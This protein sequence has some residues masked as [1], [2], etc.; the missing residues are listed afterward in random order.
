MISGV[1]RLDP[2]SL[3]VGPDGV[4]GFHWPVSLAELRVVRDHCV[5][6]LL[7]LI[8]QERQN[9]NPEAE[10]LRLIMLHALN[11]VTAIYMATA[12][13]RRA[14]ASGFA[15]EPAPGMRLAPALL[16]GE[17]PRLPDFVQTLMRGPAP[18]AIGSR[19]RRWLRSQL[20]QGPIRHGRVNWQ[21]DIVSF[22]AADIVA[23]H[24]AKAGL[25]VVYRAF[26]TWFLPVRQEDILPVSASM[27]AGLNALIVACFEAGGEVVPPIATEHLRRVFCQA[28]GTCGVH[29]KRLDTSHRIPRRLWT[30]SGA[31]IWGRM[32]RYVVRSRGGEVTG[33]DHGTGAGHLSSP[34]KPFSEFQDCSRFVTFTPRQA[35]GLRRQYDPRY[36]LD[37]AMPELV[38][39]RQ[40]SG[41]VPVVH[42][43]APKTPRKIIY[44][45]ALSD[46]EDVHFKPLWPD[47][48]L[49][50]LQARTLSRLK[51]WGFDV[52][53][54][55]YP[56]RRAIQPA[57]FA[58]RL[59]ITSLDGRFEDVLSEADVVILESHLSTTFA[60]AICSDKPIVLLDFELDAL[61]PEARQMLERRAVLVPAW[62]DESNRAQVDWTIFRAGIEESGRRFDPAFQ[63]AFFG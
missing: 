63:K 62:F 61:A 11:E 43:P 31:Q 21:T 33:H 29:L 10:W 56:S 53:Y 55:P 42:A 32:L 45:A 38:V 20:Q 58:D 46:G 16:K 9:G 17:A 7:G 39:L 51:E 26:P 50:D 44:V 13:T 57:G 14:A 24:A 52:L 48:V 59:G 40:E 5:T 8:A 36:V 22:S 34:Y 3:K 54:K 12:L 2:L 18:E 35:E 15:V 1:I 6:G 49:T 23:E 28:M 47:I 30:V 37:H 19:V 41:L 4:T 25:H 60:T 27:Q